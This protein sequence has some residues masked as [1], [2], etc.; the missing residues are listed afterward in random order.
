MNIII[1]LT[2]AIASWETSM[3]TNVLGM[4]LALPP[5]AAVVVG[6]TAWNRDS[7]EWSRATANQKVV[8]LAR[9]GASASRIAFFIAADCAHAGGGEP[10]DV[11]RSAPLARRCSA[12]AASQRA[13]TSDTASSSP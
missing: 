8:K 5:A 9:C 11:T 3:S 7:T 13:R 10:L 2:F 4:S 12:A 1:N 6:A